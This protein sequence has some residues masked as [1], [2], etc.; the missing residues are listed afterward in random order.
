MFAQA[1]QDLALLT[2]SDTH[3]PFGLSLGFDFTAEHESGLSG[4]EQLLG[5]GKDG[6]EGVDRR[7]ATVD[8]YEIARHVLFAE[9]DAT[10]TRH[11]ETVFAVGPDMAHRRDDLLDRRRRLPLDAPVVT[12]KAAEGAPGYAASWGQAGFILRAVSP[13]ARTV[14]R[15][16]FDG[17][18]DGDFAVGLGGAS[19]F[20]R[21]PLN[22]C[23]P[24]LMPAEL[25]TAILAAD[26]AHARLMRA[27]DQTGIADRLKAAGCAWRAL[28]PDWVDAFDTMPRR[29]G[30]PA[31]HTSAPVIFFLNPVDQRRHHHGWFT[32]ED[33]DAWAAGTGP[34]MKDPEP[35][36]PA[37]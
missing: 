8:A 20:A 31:D 29:T 32:V 26:R 6:S 18:Q 37:P 23:R 10:P 19:A 15:A 12:E 1:T 25:H 34:V 17:L 16:L 2:A 30:S 22:L 7:R 24:S 27:A 4:L 9:L 3:A 14:V 5:I 36:A 33:L 21:A 11:A 35:T 13:P 28:K